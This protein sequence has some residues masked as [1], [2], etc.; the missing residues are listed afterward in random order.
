M[1]FII[2]VVVIGG[3]GLIVWLK[4]SK[5]MG[6]CTKAITEEKK[7]D[8]VKSSDVISSIDKAKEGLNKKTKEQKKQIDDIKKDKKKIETYLDN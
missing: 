2:F 7:Y 4:N 6:P 3:G 5:F 8:D 1:M